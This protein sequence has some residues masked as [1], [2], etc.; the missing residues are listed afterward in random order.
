MRALRLIVASIILAAP[1]LAVPPTERIL[2]LIA[3]D[4]MRWD[5]LERHEPPRLRALAADGVRVRR[6]KPNFPSKT[7]PNHYTLVTGLR[8]ARHGMVGNDMFDAATGRFFR[9]HERSSA[10]DP[11]WWG[12]EPIWRTAERQGRISACMF[13]PGNEVAF[14]GQRPTYW[15]PYYHDLPDAERVDQV[16]AWLDLPAARRPSLITLY[17]AA[18]DDAGH[19]HGPTSPQT[20]DAL[21]ALDGEI[22]RLIDGVAARGLTEEVQLIVVSDHGM[23]DISPEQIVLLDDFIDVAQVQLDVAGPMAGVRP[24]GLELDA[25]VEQLRAVPHARVLR[26]EELPAEYGYRDHPRMAEVLVL[27][28][29]GWRITTRAKW[30][31]NRYQSDRGDHGF[32]IAYGSMDTMLLATGSAFRRETCIQTLDNIHVYNLLCAILGLAAAPND[33]DDRLIRAALNP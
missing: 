31:A 16:L 17:F 32:D 5:Y 19:R 15:R 3:I 9:M 7:F 10:N 27:A 26:R 28:D 18:L 1:L 11:Q 8:P 22:G 6:L 14:D 2:V 20:R 4:G 13:W 30:A 23:A 24:R 21:H 29:E 12:G 25:L 33:G